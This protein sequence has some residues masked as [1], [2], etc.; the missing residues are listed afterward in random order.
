MFLSNSPC[1]IWCIKRFVKGNWKS[2]EKST[3]ISSHQIQSIKCIG[4]CFCKSV[5]KIPLLTAHSVFPD[6]EKECRNSY[7]VAVGKGPI[8]GHIFLPSKERQVLKSSF[9][10]K[11]SPEAETASALHLIRKSQSKFKFSHFSPVCCR[12]LCNDYFISF[13]FSSSLVE[14]G[15]MTVLFTSQEIIRRNKIY[16]WDVIRANELEK[17]LNVI[18]DYLHPLRSLPPSAWEN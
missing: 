16:E 2:L 9:A 4:N 3:R 14:N 5:Y 6:G 12:E 18:H 10:M 8:S 13:S 11:S 1:L 17:Q 15:K 7:L